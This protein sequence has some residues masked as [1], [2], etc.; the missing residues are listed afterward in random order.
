MSFR[1]PRSSERGMR[2]LHVDEVPAT[3]EVPRPAVAGLGTTGSCTVVCQMP[4]L[5]LPRVPADMISTEHLQAPRLC[6]VPRILASGPGI[7][8]FLHHCPFRTTPHFRPA[9]R[10]DAFPSCPIPCFIQYLQNLSPPCG[11]LAQHS[12]RPSPL[13]PPYGKQGETQ[14]HLN[15]QTRVGVDR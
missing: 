8:Q 3:I 4:A 2:N 9:E 5:Q 15:V 11:R 12:H 10:A 13:I 14:W 6:I 7:V 1:M